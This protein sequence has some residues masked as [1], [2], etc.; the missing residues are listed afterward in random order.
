MLMKMQIGTWARGGGLRR[1]VKELQGGVILD[2][3]K[4]EARNYGREVALLRNSW[5]QGVNALAH[6]GLTVHCHL[7]QW[8][9]TTL[10]LPHLVGRSEVGQD[11]LLLGPAAE[12]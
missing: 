5:G 12:G 9:P 7:S 1:E 10:K 6:E 4:A 8:G 11:G 3:Q 2:N